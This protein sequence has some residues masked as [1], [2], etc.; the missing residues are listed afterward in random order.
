MIFNRLFLALIFLLF[1]PQEGASKEDIEQLSKFKF[2][3]IA[4]DEK[5]AGNALEP[6]GGIMTECDTDSLSE[7]ILS[8][9]DA[10][11]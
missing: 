9:E 1:W 6:G 7:H 8:E 3:R 10:V 4:N 11:S 2:R 5:L